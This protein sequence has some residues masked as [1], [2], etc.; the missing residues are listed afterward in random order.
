MYCVHTL[1][2]LYSY[3]VTIPILS[4]QPQEDTENGGVL[5]SEMDGKKVGFRF[6]FEGVQGIESVS[7]TQR[8]AFRLHKLTS[9]KRIK[10]VVFTF[11]G[12]LLCS[13]LIITT[14]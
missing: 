9:A 1:K 13:R 14:Q 12:R 11:I 10:E 2:I 6:G 3:T 5:S 4:P 7:I 8:K